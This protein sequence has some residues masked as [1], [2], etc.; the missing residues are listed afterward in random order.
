MKFRL[1]IFINTLFLITLSSCINNEGLIRDLPS[2]SEEKQDLSSAIKVYLSTESQI[3]ID[4]T[5]VTLPELKYKI[6]EYV[7][8]NKSES[9]ISLKYERETFYQTYIDVQN[10]IVGEI[11][12]L[13]DQLAQ[14]K[15]NSKLNELNN[16]QRDTIRKIYP[17]NLV[18]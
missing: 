8:K 6:N 9:I 12:A 2:V 15:F 3:F 17:L 10:A 4:D 11:R 5:K 14:E 18:E 1:K 7:L 13:R 16:K